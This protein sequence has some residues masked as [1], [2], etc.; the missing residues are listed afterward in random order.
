MLVTLADQDRSTWHPTEIRDGLALLD[1]LRPGVGYA[2]EL[3][4][5]AQIAAEHARAR[6]AEETDWKTIAGCYAELEARVASPIVRLNRAVAV[7]EADTP[8]AG[9]ELLADL[10]ELL[11][12]HHR[13]AAVR[14]ELARRVGNDELARSEYRRAL[15]LCENEVERAYLSDRLASLGSA[16]PD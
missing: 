6:T 11:P 3:R 2:D 15:D 14:A 13:L 16:E 9:L 4:L 12:Q 1:G 8:E 10:D 5:Q 7:A